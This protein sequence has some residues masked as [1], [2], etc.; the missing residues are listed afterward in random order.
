ME[1]KILILMHHLRLLILDENGDLLVT[2]GLFTIA[3]GAYLY[4]N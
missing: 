4:Y 3:E 2:G 1:V